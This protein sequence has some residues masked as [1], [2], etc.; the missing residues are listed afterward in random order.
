MRGRGTPSGGAVL[1]RYLTTYALDRA[2]D[3]LFYIGLG[4][5]AATSSGALGATSILAAGSVPR[6]ALLLVG[7]ALGDRWGLLRTARVTLVLRLGLLIAFAL[8]A[9]AS[10]PSALLLALVAAG[11]GLVDALHDPALTGLSGVLFQGPQL[12][13][14][15]GLMNALSQMAQM[16][17]AP[18]GGALLGW[19]GDAVGWL[20]AGLALIA[21]VALPAAE[22]DEP[23]APDEGPRE[24]VLREVGA[25][26]KQAAT[27]KDLLAM[28][29]V[30]G[31]ANFAATPAV[32]AGIPLL[33]KL[34][35]WS[36]T[37]YGVVMAGFAVGCIGG[38]A[39]LAL[40]GHRMRHPARWAAASMLP[41]SVAVAAVGV[42]GSA[43]AAAVAIAVAGVTFQGGAGALMGT[44]KDVT[45]AE[46]MG[47]M[48]SLVQ[49]SV[50]ALI[51]LGLVTFGALATASSAREAQLV[52]ACV[53]AFGGLA[54]LSVRSLR[55]V[56]L[57]DG[58]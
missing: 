24:S 46:E 18:L 38:A 41:G 1:G 20:G 32:T 54:A 42:T 4:W 31:V 30:F 16:V 14:T 17:A 52:M 50:Y 19:R 40:L 9:L 10:P 55:E 27:R 36:A 3:G 29:G 23:D 13:R 47:R 26:L 56:Q 7:G 33:A 15:Q 48:M 43:A 8:V 39:A 11:F 25:V 51:P 58:P 2:G 22:P 53:M 34:R 37:E 28:L 35:G 57:S 12:L 45:P 5:L 49:V 21:L 6:I 44:I